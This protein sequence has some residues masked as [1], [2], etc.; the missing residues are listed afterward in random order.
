MD[1]SRAIETTCVT[2]YEPDF[3]EE[4]GDYK[5][6]D[7][8]RIFEKGRRKEN[9]SKHPTLRCPCNHREYGP[10]TPSGPRA[11]WAQHT[12]QNIHRNWLS[13]Y[14]EKKEKEDNHERELNDLKKRVIQLDQRYIADQRRIEML[15]GK[16]KK[17]MI[18][19]QFD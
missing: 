6:K 17:V 7:I 11:G 1:T 19:A 16:L 10:K 5:D 13:H 18:D 2:I 9:M 3:D 8:D 15:E 12:K 14:A 4:T